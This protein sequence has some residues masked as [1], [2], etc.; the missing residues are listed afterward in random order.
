M[1]YTSAWLLKRA[2]NAKSSLDNAIVF[3]VLV[4]M[5]SMLASAVLYFLEPTIT[6]ILEALGLNMFVM[7]AGVIAVL[8]H[9]AGESD[10]V[11]ESSIGVDPNEL[12]LERS[13]KIS[14]GYVVYIL[15]MMASMIA[16]EIFYTINTALTGLEEGLIVGTIIMTAGVI[17]ILWYSSRHSTKIK[18]PTVENSQSTRSR[19]VRSILISLVLLNEFLMGWLF[20]LVSGTP[21]ISG[22]TLPQIAESTLTSVAGSDWFLFTMV[23]EIILSIYMLRNAFS[24]NFV[25]IVCL[26]SLAMLFVPTAINAPFWVNL[27]AF[28]DSV[29]LIGLILAYKNRLND[30]PVRKYSLV[31]LV[32]YSLA[33]VGFFI[34]VVQGSALLLLISIIGEMILYFNTIIERISMGLDRSERTNLEQSKKIAMT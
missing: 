27:S 12:E 16:T 31:L 19:F 8:R 33:M 10:E 22:A 23:L 25:R 26:Q 21:K 15:V 17:F 7:S 3:Y 4:M 9:W 1:A 29:I 13:V 30:Q 34:W 6:G 14:S 5:A 32:L 2:S 18:I 28:L 11:E 20:T 24:K